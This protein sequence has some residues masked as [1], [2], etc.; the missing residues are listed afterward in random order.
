MICAMCRKTNATACDRC[1]SI[2]YCS[3]ECQRED[4]PVHKALCRDMAA[5]PQRPSKEH[6]LALYFPEFEL[7]PQL[8]WIKKGSYGGETHLKSYIGPDTSRRGLDNENCDGDKIWV[9]RECLYANPRNGAKSEQRH[10]LATGRYDM[11]RSQVPLSYGAVLGRSRV[12]K[13]WRGP[14]VF[15]A[16]SDVDEVSYEDEAS[17]EDKIIDVTLADLRTVVDTVLEWPV[18]D[19]V[20]TDENRFDEE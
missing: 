13:G 11:T 19:W 18:P 1:K 20:F 16:V 6:F 17:D 5:M 12:R 14:L 7:K 8:V 9:D 4:W 15:Q 3:K 2:H 10:L